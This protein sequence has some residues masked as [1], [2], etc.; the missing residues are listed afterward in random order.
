MDPADL[1][2]PSQALGSVR[3][4]L[5]WTRGVRASPPCSI[6]SA[7]DATVNKTQPCPERTSVS[8]SLKLVVEGEGLGGDCKLP[9]IIPAS[10]YSYACASSSSWW[11]AG[12]GDSFPTT[13]I[14]QRWWD[15]TSDVSWQKDCNSEGSH[16]VP[17][18]LLYREVHV[19]RNLGRAPPSPPPANSQLGADAFSQT[20][21]NKLNL[22]RNDVSLL[23]SR[24][25]PSWALRWDSSPGQHCHSSLLRDL[26]VEGPSQVCLDAWPTE[27]VS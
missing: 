7:R 4:G 27:T 3:L 17:F 12:P 22:A 18:E 1:K 24:C 14:S 25:L 10:R 8:Y 19:V 11:R 9:Q 20:A 26:E 21:W 5:S 6:L 15:V 16:Q 2:I 13:K 23:A